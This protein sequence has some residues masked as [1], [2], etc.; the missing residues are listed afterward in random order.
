MPSIAD[1][2]ESQPVQKEVTISSEGYALWL[3]WHGEPAPTVSQTL[4]DYGGLCVVSSENQALWYFFSADALLALAKLVVWGKYNPLAMSVQAMP[5]T[6]RVGVGQTLCVVLDKNLGRQEVSDPGSGVLV[7]VHP[8]LRE[9]GANLPGL[10]YT[11]GEGNAGM[12]RLKWT[13]LGADARLPYASSQGWYALLRPLGNPLDKAFQ[14]GWRALFSRLEYILQTEKL[15][16]SLSENF[17][18]LPLDNL[19]QLRVWVKELLQTLDDVRERDM[20]TYWPC[21]SAVVDKRGLNFNNELPHKVNVNWDELMPDY[22]YM[23]YR[24]AY[25]LGG[26]YTIQDLHFSTTSTSV[27][28]W[29]T[30]NLA[31]QRD[32]SQSVPLLMAAQLVTGGEPCLYCGVRTHH[33]NQCPSRRMAPRP[34]DFWKNFS[35]LDIDIINAAYRDIEIKLSSDG[36]AGYQQMLAQEGPQARVLEGIFAIQ[37]DIQIRSLER[38]WMLSGKDIEA[39]PVEIAGQNLRDDSPGWAMIERLQRASPNEIGILEKE[40]A[41]AIGRTPRDWHLQCLMGFVAAERGD[42][43]KAGNFWHEAETLCSSV[44]HQSWHCFLQGR[45]LELRGKFNEASDYFETAKRLLP[46]WK[47]PEYRRIVCKVKQGFAVQALI[48]VLELVRQ[49]PSFFNLLLLDPELERGRKPILTALFPLWQDARKR[50]NAERSELERLLTEINEW[51]PTDHLAGSALS[52]RLQNMLEQADVKNYI[53]FLNMVTLRPV[54]EEELEQLIQKEITMLQEKFKKY[55]TKLEVVRDEASWFP[56]QRALVEFNRDFNKGASML[57]WA[58]TADFHTPEAFCKAQ[59]HLAP[60]DELLERLDKRLRVLRMVRDSTLYILIL[61]R[62]FLWVEIV[63]LTLCLIGV[64]AILF[65]GDSFGMSWIQRLI[66]AN[67]WELQQVLVTIIS[68]A[69]LGVAA[70]RTTLVFEKRRDTMLEE[71]RMQREE[72][73]RVRLQRAKARRAAQQKQENM[74]KPDAKENLDDEE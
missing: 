47:I 29:C 22:P 31:E 28:N 18:M 10:S 27:D 73:Q 70:L 42:L 40:L 7:W 3:V 69:A 59:A 35:D 5:G 36:N 23:S 17:L 19:N 49:D 51:F 11:P 72:M 25:L 45:A 65:Y 67:F 53:N 30:V 71:A 12:A 62:S 13:L 38:I 46:Q 24:N 8:K 33:S 55:L 74:R 16:Y 6:L 63:A 52:N 44:L 39:D 4:Q 32:R 21:I 37:G 57:N 48:R 58:F 66:K 20:T 2:L 26:D 41:I 64:L 43:L 50:C 68:I 56:F 9:I 54:I 34:L 60:L 15:K 1:L 61:T 14:A